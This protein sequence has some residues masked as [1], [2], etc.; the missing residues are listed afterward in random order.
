MFGMSIADTLGSAIVLTKMLRMPTIQD[1]YLPHEE[2]KNWENE[3]VK[4]QSS[5]LRHLVPTLTAFLF[6]HTRTRP[7]YMEHPTKNYTAN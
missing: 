2:T 1:E 7:C 6:Y 3:E 4:Q 5:F